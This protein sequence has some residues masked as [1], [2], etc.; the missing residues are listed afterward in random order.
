MDGGKVFGVAV[1]V[2]LFAEGSAIATNVVGAAEV[3]CLVGKAPRQAALDE[4]NGIDGPALEQL[5]EALPSGDGIVHGES[6]PVPDVEVSAGIQ[7]AANIP[8]G[9]RGCREIR[10]CPLIR[11]HAERMRKGISTRKRQAMKVTAS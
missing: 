11:R 9:I 3:G 4:H 8:I 2:P 6:E 10:G 5:S 7:F 1:E